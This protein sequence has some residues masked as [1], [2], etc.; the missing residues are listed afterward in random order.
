VDFFKPPHRPGAGTHRPG[1]GIDG[2][3]SLSLGQW[4]TGPVWLSWQGCQPRRGRSCCAQDC[5]VHATSCRLACWWQGNGMLRE[6]GPATNR[7]NGRVPVVVQK[8]AARTAAAAGRMT[9]GCLGGGFS[10]AWRRWRRHTSACVNDFGQ[11]DGEERR[12]TRRGREGQHAGSGMSV[13]GL[14]TELVCA[15]VNLAGEPSDLRLWCSAGNGI[16]QRFRISSEADVCAPAFL[17]P[18]PGP[19]GKE[20]QG[21]PGECGPGQ[22]AL[23]QGVHNA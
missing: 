22:R 14:R 1:A 3:Q 10:G 12:G 5:A 13:V 9:V 4:R 23:H 19:G 8:A 11:A 21:E 2:T 17:R 6:T 15:L 20:G 18:H 16:G 7:M